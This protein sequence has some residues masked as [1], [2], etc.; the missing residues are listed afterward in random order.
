MSGPVY[1][2]NWLSGIEGNIG[3]E[4]TDNDINIDTLPI[5]G[6]HRPRRSFKRCHSRTRSPHA[7]PLTPPM[8]TTP[9]KRQRRTEAPLPHLHG[10]QAPTVAAVVNSIG[11]DVDE[12]VELGW[13]ADAD[14]GVDLDLDIDP[15]DTPRQH[16]HHHSRA[17]STKTSS[18][19]S[20]TSRDTV[21]TTGT[22][23][24]T[25]TG[26]D[27]GSRT[28]ASSPRKRLA[29]LEIGEHAV[30]SHPLSLASSHLGRLPMRLTRLMG[31]LEDVAIGAR[32]VIPIGLREQF[33][34]FSSPS[35]EHYNTAVRPM[36]DSIFAPETDHDHA[37]SP[38]P[39]LADVLGILYEATRAHD[40]MLDEA[41]WN[42]AVHF[43]LLKL[44]LHG[45]L[46]KRRRQLVDIEMC[47]TAGI[48]AEYHHVH[49]S[50][51]K[52]VD[53]VLTLE[54][55]AD[56]DPYDSAAAVRQVEQIRSRSPC[57]SINHTAF[58]PLLKCPIAVSIE[59]K[60]PGGGGAEGATVQAGV[61]AAAQ[62]SSLQARIEKQH[63]QEPQQQHHHHQGLPEDLYLPAMVVVGHDWTLA[64]TTRTGTKT[65]L[66]T[67]FPIG[68]TR[69]VIGIYRL[70]W[71]IQRVSEWA[72]SEY[73]PWYKMAVLGIRR[74]PDDI[75]VSGL[76]GSVGDCS[77]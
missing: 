30:D 45:S 14:A 22:R 70:V 28:G 9:R 52:K 68:D 18:R 72:S 2:L 76:D 34:S 24:G 65:T 75:A 35:H 54:P 77:T 63:M 33:R 7:L 46:N 49:S 10:E 73:W 71:A 57:F 53:F 48:I 40:K 1:I 60:R 29:R 15:D 64:A 16:H 20:T 36:P 61:W 56:P 62:W 51:P 37:L 25:G 23:S 74:L 4:E 43:P 66:W 50:T 38:S 32:P 69:S 21:T 39:A 59:T 42:A 8:S 3:L 13:D 44:A 67:D 31:D 41:G 12:D 58:E 26:T 6:D 19:S 27:T 11:V 47:T 17:R 5:S 55:S